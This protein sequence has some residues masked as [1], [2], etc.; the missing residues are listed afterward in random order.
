MT[1]SYPEVP[2][3]AEEEEAFTCAEIADAW[4]KACVAIVS[5]PLTYA[6][7]SAMPYSG[8]PKDWP[9]W[10]HQKQHHQGRG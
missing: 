1:T 5:L 9:L 7:Q 10:T 3:T 6:Q 2:V 4:L 8:D